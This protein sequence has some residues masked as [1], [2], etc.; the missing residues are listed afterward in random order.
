[1]P[2]RY[3]AETF[4]DGRDNG[5][6]P[7]GIEICVRLTSQMFSRSD[8]TVCIDGRKP[9]PNLEEIQGQITENQSTGMKKPGN[10]LNMFSFCGN[11]ARSL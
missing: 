3:L 6:E 2:T 5:H 11:V 9:G 1:M 7:P 8:V 10:S 4:A